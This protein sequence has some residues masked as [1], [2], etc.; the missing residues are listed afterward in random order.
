MK[1]VPVEDDSSEESELFIPEVS[2][3]LYGEL[4]RQA[5]WAVMAQPWDIDQDGEGLLLVQDAR[6]DSWE[7]FFAVDASG[8]C[9][10]RVVREK[11][12]DEAESG[13]S[14]EVQ[15][16]S[17]DFLQGHDYELNVRYA[18]EAWDECERDVI[19]LRSFS[20][21]QQTHYPSADQVALLAQ[22]LEVMGNNKNC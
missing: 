3:Q 19:V 21:L 13:D 22:A 12:A 11:G 2:P 15:F 1:L 8:L 4:F 9:V 16:M 18:P 5:D 10:L 17:S 6:G 20:L 14:L 7:A